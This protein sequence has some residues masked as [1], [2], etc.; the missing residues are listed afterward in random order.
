MTAVSTKEFN[1]HQER[2]FKMAVVGKVYIPRSDCMLIVKRAGEEEP[3]KKQ[4]PVPDFFKRINE[5]LKCA[6]FP[7][8]KKTTWYVFFNKYRENEK[9]YFVVRH[10]ENNHTAAKYFNQD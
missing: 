2:Y 1:T 7:K 3:N 10:I 6:Y 4:R 5:K 9:T 8:T